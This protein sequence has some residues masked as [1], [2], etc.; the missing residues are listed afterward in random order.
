[1][2]LRY[3]APEGMNDVLPESSYLWC[4]VE[5]CWRDHCHRYGYGEI[6]TP[7]LET[8]ALFERSV[9]ET[10]DIVSKEMY[11]LERGEER[12]A[13]KPEGTAPV[14]RAYIEHGLHASG[15]VQKLYYITPFFRGERPQKGR[16]RQA[17]Q[18]GAEIFGTAHPLADAELLAMVMAFFAQLGIPEHALELRL[19]TIGCPNCRPAYRNAVYQ[20]GQRNF[21]RLCKNCQSRLERNPLRILDCKECTA[22]T[23]NAP[24]ID[25]YLCSDCCA[26]FE[27]VQELLNTLSVR[28]VRDHRLVRGLDYYTRTTFEVVADQGLGAQNALCGGGRYDGLVEALGGPSTPAL[29]VGI[30]V[31]RTLLVLHALNV[32]L[33]SPPRIDAFIVAFSD[34]ARLTGLQLAQHLRTAGVTCDIDLEGRSPKAQMR[35][36]NRSGARCA[37]LLGESELAT[38]TATV[39]DLENHEQVAVPQ[40]ELTEWIRTRLSCR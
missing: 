18:F 31:E 16:Y 37:I 17:H 5:A 20:F 24:L 32:A 21:S 29:G 27:K 10:S 39:K 3:R 2:E 26:H 15:S 13:L 40:A 22:T 30:G 33:P 19:N 14:A 36:A 12:Y 1:M 25:P 6:R 34:E 9:G 7:I 38:A 11:V 28:Y 4:F 23:M 35:L 8:A